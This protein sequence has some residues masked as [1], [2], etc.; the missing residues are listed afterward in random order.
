MKDV[1]VYYFQNGPKTK[2]K[3][4]GLGD[5]TIKI[6]ILEHLGSTDPISQVKRVKGDGDFSL[7]LLYQVHP[8]RCS[9]N[10]IRKIVYA[11]KGMGTNGT[12]RKDV[13]AS[14]SKSGSSWKASMVYQPKEKLKF[15]G[16]LDRQIQFQQEKFVV[17]PFLLVS[18]NLQAVP[19]E[20]KPLLKRSQRGESDLIERSGMK[21]F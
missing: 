20:K 9:T 7:V 11:L 21:E 13:D 2:E 10:A 19:Q 18:K 4:S 17:I 1:G 12:G 8:Q 6:G 3:K 16:I 15:V 5:G 14:V